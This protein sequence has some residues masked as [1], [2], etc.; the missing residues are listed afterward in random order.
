MVGAAG[1]G[2]FLL[3]RKSP[4]TTLS[5]TTS[6]ATAGAPPAPT[7]YNQAYYLQYQYPAMVAQ[8]PNITNPNYTLTQAQANQYLQNYLE[9]QQ[10]ITT[11]VPKPFATQLAALQYHWK[12]YGVALK[13]TY[14]PLI[15]PKNANWTPPPANANSSGSSSTFS[16][17]L[18]AATS[19]IALLGDKQ[20]LNDADLELL[21][22]GCAVA[23]NIVPLYMKADPRMSV[24]IN[25]K[26][27]E[28]LTDYI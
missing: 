10:W 15:P 23:K 28:V 5:T 1:I 27:D 16:T 19:I 26:M 18:G 2:L 11:V 25:Q 20:R 14:L 13:Y 4:A 22:N 21:F 3:T 17:I 7:S 8:D 24:L 6:V 12:T 9:L